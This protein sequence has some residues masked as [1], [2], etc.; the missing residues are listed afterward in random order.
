MQLVHHHSLFNGFKLYH[1]RRNDFLKKESEYDQEIPQSQ[2]QTNPRH[3]EEEP[4]NIYSTET[5]E[6]Q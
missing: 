2:L 3:R 5:S 4:K 6:R 1:E